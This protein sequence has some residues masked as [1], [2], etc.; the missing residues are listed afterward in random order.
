M[1]RRGGSDFGASGG[2]FGGELDHAVVGEDDL[3]AVGDE[4]L[5][6]GTALDGEAGFAELFDFG[7]EGHGVEDDAVADDAPGLRA[8]DAAGNELE[9][10]LAAADD[11]GV[12]GVVAASVAGD[13]VEAAR[14]GRRR[15]CLC[16]RR[17]IGHRGLP[18]ICV[19]SRVSLAPGVDG[20]GWRVRAQQLFYTA[21]IE[22]IDAQ[23]GVAANDAALD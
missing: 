10:E 20:V 12:S 11:D 21:G 2:V 13:D 19:G 17:P 14:R 7:E 8:E 3:G 15:S 6:V 23:V 18:L 16:L 1:P 4:E 22:A 9:D 5:A